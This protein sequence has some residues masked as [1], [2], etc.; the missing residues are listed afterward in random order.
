MSEPSLRSLGRIVAHIPAR[1]G[2]KRVKS[3]NL[4]ILAGKPMIQYAIE[5]A[6]AV[7]DLDELYVNTDSREITVL[8]ESLGTRV[9][10]RDSALA[11]DTASGDDFTID[12]IR[13]LKPDTLLMVS[14]VCP[15]VTPGD[16]REA[17][18]VYRRSEADTLITCTT[19]RMQTFVEGEPVNIRPQEPLAPSQDN[20]EIQILNWAVTIWEAKTF[21]RNYDKYRGG[22]LGAKRL[23]QPIDP[24]H[25][26]KVSYEEDFRLVEALL[27]ARLN[28]PV[29]ATPRYWQAAPSG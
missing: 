29:E 24:L 19:T 25:A 16:I 7:E 15:L 22:Y 2:S 6:Q 11:S 28:H 9:Y 10:Q 12:I 17:I 21:V 27:Q 26:I 20:P 14:P 5:A 3:K 13:R 18:A 1:A 23:L 8:A 4:R